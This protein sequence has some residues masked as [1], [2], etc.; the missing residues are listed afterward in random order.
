MLLVLWMVMAMVLRLG[1]LLVHSK[2]DDAPFDAKW[3]TLWVSMV[4]ACLYFAALSHF[5]RALLLHSEA[6]ARLCLAVA[7]LY[8]SLSS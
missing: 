7:L 3:A 8:R 2:G 6:S 1:A 5:D 4:A